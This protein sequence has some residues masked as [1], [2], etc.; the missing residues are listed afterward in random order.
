VGAAARR[1]RTLAEALADPAALLRVTVAWDQ[2]DRPRW[3]VAA[4]T[5]HYMQLTLAADTQQRL[6]A[7]L[8]ETHP[9]VNWWIAH[10]V[11][12]D[13]GRIGAAPQ[14]LDAG[15]IP[16]DDRSFGEPRPPVLVDHR[17]PT[18]PWPAAELR[19]AA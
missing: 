4:W 6:F 15:Y 18:F 14:L 9:A 13:T 12:L 1:G 2:A 16:Q 8:R 7:D 3:T 11:D 17:T 5:D 10:Q 19:R